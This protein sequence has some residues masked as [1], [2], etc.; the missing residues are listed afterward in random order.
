[1]ST[2]AIIIEKSDGW[3]LVADSPSI[4]EKVYFGFG[5][6]YSITPTIPTSNIVSDFQT[7]E[8]S[9]FTFKAMNN[10]KFYVRNFSSERMVLSVTDIVFGPVS[11]PSVTGSNADF[12][13]GLDSDYFLKADNI[14]TTKDYV[15]IF[16]SEL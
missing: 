1:M 16:E 2:R 7:L 5:G 15:A 10:N 6:V 4:I 11:Q 13:D 8:S 14:T 12:L 9:D 3:K